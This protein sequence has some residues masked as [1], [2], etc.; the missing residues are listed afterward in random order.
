MD[1]ITKKDFK[2]KIWNL[3]CVGL[4]RE[5]TTDKGWNFKSCPMY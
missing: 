5:E 4:I 3:L 1:V 2:L